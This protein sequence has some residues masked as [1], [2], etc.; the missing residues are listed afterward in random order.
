MKTK[1]VLLLCTIWYGN[2][3]GA[4]EPIPAEYSCPHQFSKDQFPPPLEDENQKSRIAADWKRQ[5]SVDIAELEEPFL[6]DKRAAFE[7]RMTYQS[8]LLDHEA[9]LWYDSLQLLVDE[10][11][12]RLLDH[13]DIKEED[14][15]RFLLYRSTI[16]NASCLGEGTMLLHLAL[17]Y[18]LRSTEQLAFVMAHELAHYHLNHVNQ[19]IFGRIEFL[20]SETTKKKAKASRKGKAFAN[21]ELLSWLGNHQLNLNQH[22][23]EHEL[24]TDSLG[25][26]FFLNAGFAPSAALAALQA[27][28]VIDRPKYTVPPLETWFDFPDFPWREHWGKSQLSGL[29]LV[30]PSEVDDPALRTHPKL[31]QR[32]RQVRA[33]LPPSDSSSFRDDLCNWHPSMELDLLRYH[34]QTRNSFAALLGGLEILGQNPDHRY[35]RA[36]IA[37]TLIDLCW[38]RQ[39]HEYSK[40]IPPPSVRS[41][42]DGAFRL[43]TFLDHLSYSELKSIA[44]QW[45]MATLPRLRNIEIKTALSLKLEALEGGFADQPAGWSDFTQ[46]WPNSIFDSF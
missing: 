21:R 8:D 42:R 24:Q 45:G 17:A 33:L 18:R 27:L 28:A 34:Y 46:R 23:R 4:Q 7:R 30:Q 10:L 26:V 36:I 12:Q 2:L 15:V 39:A 35:A 43:A 25:L 40:R 38:A 3:I 44:Q 29:S 31:E 22:S 16:P 5:L 32:I 14:R 37:H 19:R 9:F 1:I 6:K 41:M 13:N 20:N 11:A